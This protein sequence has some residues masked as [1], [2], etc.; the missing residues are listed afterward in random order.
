LIPTLAS[1]SIIQAG[2][3]SYFNKHI[4]SNRIVVFVGKISYPMYM[5]HWPLLVFSRY[6][7]PPGST[8]I[9]SNLHFIIAITVIISILTYF[10]FENPVRRSKSKIFVII[11]LF[12]MLSIGAWSYLNLRASRIRNN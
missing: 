9:F 3:E 11:L 4:L 1:A 10:F 12:F 7:Y 8:S 6:L 5:W 2:N